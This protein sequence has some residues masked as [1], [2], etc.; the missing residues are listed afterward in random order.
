MFKRL[1]LA[2]TARAVLALRL[3]LTA[4]LANAGTLNSATTTDQD[5]G[6]WL[7]SGRDEAGTYHSPLSDINASNV[8]KLG[9]AWE[10]KLGTHR[11]LEATPV[12]VDGVLY[13]SGNFGTVYAL[14]AATGRERWVYDPGV[15]GQYG[16]YACCDAVNRG[17]AVS[18]G[19]VYV[20]ALDGYLHA[21]DAATGRRVWKVDSL[22]LR[23]SRAPYT[24]T[25]APVI[26]GD[27]VL[28]GA[29]GGDFRGVRGYV[30]AFDV[31]TGKLQWRF[32]TVP[33]NPAQ[34]AQDQ[35]HLVDAIKT[36][37]V[38]HRWE[39]GGGGPVWD[40]ISYD[41]VAKLIYI[42]TGNAAPYDIK[43]DGR[44]GGDDL[45]TASIIALR[46]SGRLAWHYQVVPGDMWDFD[47]TQ[48]MV[49][50]DLTL[51]KKR[52]K[53][54]MQAS[55]NGFYYVLDRITGKLISAAPF[56]F[57][58][59]T[60]GI[61]PK[62]GRPIPNSSVDYARSPKMIFPW[63][64]GAHSWQPMSFDRR[65][66]RA[67]IPVMEMGDVQFES[68]HLPAGLVEG[69]FTSPMVP[70][71]DYDPKA[72]ANLYGALP[73]LENLD[74]GL[75]PAQGRAFLRAW[76]PVKQRLIW[77]VPTEAYW[78]GGV[79]STDGGLVIQG[80][81][82]GRLNVYAASTG[83]LLKRTELGSSIM[84]APMTYRVGNIQYIA[85]MAGY[86]GGQIGAPLPDNSAAYRYGN[87]GRII[88]LQI[89]GGP[90]PLPPTVVAQPVPRPP[91]HEGTRAEIDAGDVLYNRFCSRCHVFGRG[92]LPDLR[93]LTPAQHQL[94]YDIVLKGMLAPLG[95][96]RFDDQLTRSDAEA[97]H[98]YIV[99]QAWAGSADQGDK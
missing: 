88:A 60:Q 71:E 83:Q 79:L 42:G 65:T 52:R 61:D 78:D 10:Y 34:G 50:A 84:A 57:V 48:K 15:D 49:L 91:A 54:L 72:L 1:R 44:S 22:P 20:A 27:L 58:N 8:S 75:P 36:W 3:L 14:D 12:M 89:G 64:G 25:G 66:Q 93:R 11:G 16:R 67:F 95:M 90:V 76:D 41:P 99:D 30:A 96:G 59:W 62:T 9:F 40:G 74:E 98:A 68:S 29:G 77:E 38:R 85:V 23:N 28:I 51:D 5:P 35:P 56:A 47:S 24:V 81:I 45:Y 18:K 39:Q 19:R 26:A 7:K 13:T 80:D 6:Q 4:S 37:D 97:I 69:Q 86:G 92:V 32:Y 63:E 94:F 17:V 46:E 2:A 31:R 82:A 43:E 55:K 21:I 87:E 53:V 33:R 73:P 70:A